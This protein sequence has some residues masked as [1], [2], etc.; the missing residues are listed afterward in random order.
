MSIQREDA[1]THAWLRE[2][3]SELLRYLQRHHATDPRTSIVSGK[4]KDVLLMDSA[5]SLAN[6]DDS[7]RS[8]KFKHTTGILYVAARDPFG[9]R[10][11]EGSLLKTVVHEL[12]HATREKDFG[13]FDESHNQSWKQ[14]WLWL[15]EIATRHLGWTVEV[16]CSQCT[17]YGLCRR[18]QCPKCTWLSKLCKPYVGPPGP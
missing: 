14:T 12:A 3:V 2:R 1:E 13:T 9:Q 15:L 6:D 4:L 17:Y 16:K 18:D 10:R 8:G 11:S 5:D 7:W